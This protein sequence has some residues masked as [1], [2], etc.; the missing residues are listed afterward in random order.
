[1]RM[2]GIGGAHDRGGR[3]VHLAVGGLNRQS[4]IS[5]EVIE[6]GVVA[7]ALPRLVSNAAMHCRWRLRVRERTRSAGARCARGRSQWHRR[8]NQASRIG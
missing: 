6:G 2:W 5:D 7:L 1:M 4:G 8:S 3:D